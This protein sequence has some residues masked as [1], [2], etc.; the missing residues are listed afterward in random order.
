METGETFRSE[1][2]AT[3]ATEKLTGRAHGGSA[4]RPSWP[5]TNVAYGTPVGTV[6]HEA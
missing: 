4:P 5:G 3:I 2:A 1:V 6:V